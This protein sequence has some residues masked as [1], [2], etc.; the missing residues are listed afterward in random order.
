MAL[1]ARDKQF[2]EHARLCSL[3]TT[4]ANEGD[5]DAAIAS[6]IRKAVAERRRERWGAMISLHPILMR[7]IARTPNVVFSSELRPDPCVFLHMVEAIIM[8]GLDHQVPR[9]A[10][11]H[12][13]EAHCN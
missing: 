12:Y 7:T 11:T 10:L 13:P 8:H 2:R 1:P 6:G 9:V 3:I 4:I 5:I